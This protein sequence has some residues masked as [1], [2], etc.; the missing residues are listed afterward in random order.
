MKEVHLPSGTDGPSDWWTTDGPAMV[1][2]LRGTDVR[3]VNHS[4]YKKDGHAPS[5]TKRSCQTTVAPA[6]GRTWPWVGRPV[7]ASD[8]PQCVTMTKGWLL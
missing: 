5:K 3:S 7:V 8:S 4:P 6:L 1:H 2:A